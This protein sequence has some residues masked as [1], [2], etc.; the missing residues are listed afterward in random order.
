MLISDSNGRTGKRRGRVRRI[1]MRPAAW[2]GAPAAGAAN[3][4]HDLAQR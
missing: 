4:H 2:R 1:A 3:L